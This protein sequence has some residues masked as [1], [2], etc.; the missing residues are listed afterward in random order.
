MFGGGFVLSYHRF[1]LG[2]G[3][4]RYV[5]RRFVLSYRG[6]ALGV[7]FRSYKENIRRLS[8]IA[9]IRPRNDD[10]VFQRAQFYDL[11][12]IPEIR[13]SKEIR[14]HPPTHREN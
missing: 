8:L 11:K 13:I 2:V 7:G 9:P 12:T 1:V 5:W 4:G 3:L 14:T 10:A 6:F